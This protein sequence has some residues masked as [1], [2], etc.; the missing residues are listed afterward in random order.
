MTIR[1]KMALPAVAALLVLGMMAIAQSAS[2]THARPKAATP[3]YASTVPA[4]QPCTSPNRTHAA[5]LSYASCNPPVPTSTSVTVGTP[6]ANGA[7]ANSV[8]FIK[9]VVTNGAGTNDADVLITSNISD[10]RCQAGTT[11]CSGTA[12]TADG[13]DYTGGLRLDMSLNITD[14]NNA[15]CN[16]TCGTFTDAATGTQASFPIVVPCT[17]NADPA[18]GGVCAVSTTAN[19]VSPGSV[20]EGKR[21]IYEVSQLQ[22]FDGGSD[23]NVATNP[24]TLFSV[25]GIFI[26]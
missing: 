25:Q 7:A 11:A 22:V 8:G 20:V 24:N 16:P 12:N 2:A 1:R 26:P 4:Y 9:M 6:D 18:T 3:L 5:P 17:G 19:T 23:G 14:H 15:V 13:P 10:V 21:G